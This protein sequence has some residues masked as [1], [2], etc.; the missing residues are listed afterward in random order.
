MQNELYIQKYIVF[1]VLVFPGCIHYCCSNGGLGFLY[2]TRIPKTNGEFEWYRNRL[3]GGT[4]NVCER[5]LLEREIITL[6]F[7]CLFELTA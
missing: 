5:L 7:P 4:T 2:S 1:L 3:L 6:F